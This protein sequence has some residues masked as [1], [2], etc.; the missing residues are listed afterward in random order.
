MRS[1]FAEERTFAFA[2]KPAEYRANAA[3]MIKCAEAA[4]TAERVEYVKLA[5][6]WS[7]LA[8]GAD[9]GIQQL[10]QVWSLL[11]EG[12]DVGIQPEEPGEEQDT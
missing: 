1:P 10:A 2:D 4:A 8:E 7:L 12:A 9:I 11:A 3:E 6:A 5:K